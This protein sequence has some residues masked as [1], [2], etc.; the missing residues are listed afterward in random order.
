MFQTAIAIVLVV[1]T[2]C[3]TE[4]PRFRGLDRQRV[5]SQQSSAPYNPRGWQPQGSSFTLPKSQPQQTYGAPNPAPSYGP[6]PQEQ[7]TTTES[8]AEIATDLPHQHVY[9][10]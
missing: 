6:P 8:A 2:L 4:P 9:Y 7:P 5:P 1:A 3:A 10:F